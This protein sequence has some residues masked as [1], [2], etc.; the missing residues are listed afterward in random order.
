MGGDLIGNS[1][2]PL[3]WAEESRPF[4][5]SRF[6]T[7]AVRVILSAPLFHAPKVHH[8]SAQPNRLGGTD[9]NSGGLKGR[10]TI[11]PTNVNDASTR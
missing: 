9:I 3:L 1:T 2:A 11:A 10:D 8:S 5:P 4:R 6:G 7:T